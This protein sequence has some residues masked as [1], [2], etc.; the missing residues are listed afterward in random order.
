MNRSQRRAAR[1][2]APTS[3]RAYANA[4]RCPDCD[5]ETATPYTDAHGVWHLEVRHDETCPTYLRLL[6]EGRAS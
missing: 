4:Y 2:R 3:V 5:S 6:A 1:K